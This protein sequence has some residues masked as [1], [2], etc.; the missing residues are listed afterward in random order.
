MTRDSFHGIGRGSS[1]AEERWHQAAQAL[2]GAR[3]RNRKANAVVLVEGR[4]DREAL[5]GL[6]FSGPIEVLNRGWP[7]DDVLVF[8][9]E[10]YGRRSQVDRGPSVIVLMDW[11][12]TGGRLQAN[13]RR[14][15]ESLD[16]GFDEQ[17]RSVLMRC[18]KPETRVV[19]GLSGLV[20]VLGPLVDMYDD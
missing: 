9:V 7:V 17:L 12:R 3:L 4:R 13:I 14:N 18:L 15:L 19:E 10:T 20:D 11:D 8:L 16:V 5:E 2:A 1:N 6:G